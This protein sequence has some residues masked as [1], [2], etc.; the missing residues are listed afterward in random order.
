MQTAEN[1][2]AYANEHAI[3]AGAEDISSLDFSDLEKEGSYRKDNGELK[4]DVIKEI[5][6]RVNSLKSPKDTNVKQ[7]DPVKESP[8]LPKYI[9]RHPVLHNS[10]VYSVG[11][12]VAGKIDADSLTLLLAAGAVAEE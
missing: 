2:L 6:K 9:V 11:E 4:A 1:V 3:K 10:V 5:E 7:N 12:N 8:V